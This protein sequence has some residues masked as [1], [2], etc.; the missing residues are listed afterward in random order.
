[1]ENAMR[2]EQSEAYL[3]SVE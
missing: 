3:V 1:M 2:A